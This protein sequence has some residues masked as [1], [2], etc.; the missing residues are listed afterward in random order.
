MRYIYTLL[1]VLQRSP[2]S[3][4]FVFGL[5]SQYLL[6]YKNLKN[7][8]GNINFIIYF[9]HNF[10]E[11]YSTTKILYILLYFLIILIY[12]L[13]LNLSYKNRIYFCY[14]II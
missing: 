3:L 11:R 2:S 8:N 10:P 12:L 13:Y 1:C 7:L 6:S 5:C 14:N 4:L 9:P